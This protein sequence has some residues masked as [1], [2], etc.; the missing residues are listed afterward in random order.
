ML[1]SLP[2]TQRDLAEHPAYA[3]RPTW[4]SKHPARAVRP[5]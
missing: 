1:P 3:A 2:V 5:A 4:L